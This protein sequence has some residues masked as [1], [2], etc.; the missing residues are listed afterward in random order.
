M[1]GQIEKIFI[2][3][4]IRTSYSFDSTI[5]IK[6][7]VG[8]CT[9]M[10]LPAVGRA[11]CNLFN[12]LEFADLLS[13][14]RIQPIIGCDITLQWLV[15]SSGISNFSSGKL[16]L[17]ASNQAGYKNLLKLATKTYERNKEHPFATLEDLAIYSSGIIALTGTLQ[18]GI[19]S[20]AR[21]SEQEKWLLSSI[22]DIYGD[23]SV[24]I[25]IQRHGY[26]DEPEFEFFSC[27]LANELKLP[28][29]ATNSVF[30]LGKEQY[31][32]HDAL[33]CI[34]NKTYVGMRDRIKFLP[35][36]YLRSAE[37]MIKIFSDKPEAIVNT[38]SIA[39]RCS[40]WPSKSDVNLPYADGSCSR[41]M[42]QLARNGLIEKRPII[43]SHSPFEYEEYEKRLE[44]ELDL[45]NK[46]NFSGYFTIVSDF[47]QWAKNNDIPVGPGRGSAAGSLVSW[48]LGIIG[49]DPL[50]FGLLFERFLNPD[51]ISMPDID[52]DICQDGR[53]RVIDYV[54]KKYGEKCVANIIT[55]GT[56]Q[57]RAALRDVGRVLQLPYG[58]IDKICR[59][60]PS[61]AVNPLTLSQVLEHDENIRKLYSEDETVK[62][63]IDIC[64][65]L[66][67][68]YRHSSLH[69]AGV[70]IS[71]YE[72]DDSMPIC[73]DPKTGDV[74]TQ[75]S[76]KFVEAAG[77]IKFDFLGLRTLTVINNA[78]KL[79]AKKFGD[80]AK[81]DSV[82]F[83]DRDVFDLLS[84]GFSVGV[85]HLEGVLM[86]NTMKKLKPDCL[87]D[88][89]ALL[90]LNRPGPIDNIGLYIDR[91]QGRVKIDY[92]HD[93]LKSV[94]EETFGIPVYQEQVMMMA[95]VVAGY[96]LGAAD[97]LR[98]AMGKKERLEMERQRDNFIEGALQNGYTKDMAHSLFD[99]IEKF[100]GYGFNKSHA[101]A[102]AIISYQTAWLKAKFTV[103]Y[104]V[105]FMNSEM[106]HS[107]ALIPAIYESQKMG[108]QILPPDVNSS[109][110]EFSISDDKILY[111]LGACKNVGVDAANAIV[112][113]RIYGGRFKSLL[114]FVTRLGSKSKIV[115]KRT[116]LALAKAGAFES[117]YD[118]QKNLINNIE[119]IVQ[120]MRSASS[121]L[122]CSADQISIWEDNLI[123]DDF[124]PVPPDDYC[125]FDKSEKLKEEFEA[126]GLLLTG[127][128]LSGMKK[129]LA[130]MGVRN[131]D[132]IINISDGNKIRLAGMVANSQ[133]KPGRVD[134]FVRLTVL[135]SSGPFQCSLYDREAIV[136]YSDFLKIGSI[137]VLE[138]R[139]TVRDGS[140]SLFVDKV[141]NAGGLN[142]GSRQIQEKKSRPNVVIY[143]VDGVDVVKLKNIL[144]IQNVDS[145]LDSTQSDAALDSAQLPKKI[146]IAVTDPFGNV[147]KIPLPDEEYMASN[148]IIG[149]LKRMIGVTKVEEY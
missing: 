32:S 31:K 72:I 135:D 138:I 105:A 52:V 145:T 137:L 34:Q 128:P 53:D 89:I 119:I 13:R 116:L 56:L 30:F 55:F 141:L 7:L 16:L 14:S 122:L 115:N 126:L 20:K 131:S 139:I 117:I 91:K 74:V 6:P 44:F 82:S 147:K 67:G 146:W 96:S 107:D 97:I 65:Q 140:R 101:A 88:L 99:L 29:V 93:N 104:L 114:D 118:K 149:A 106:H 1:R 64:V 27:A 22:V 111:S 98:R 120:S 49:L 63:M 11:D 133:T 17:I 94:L 100:A 60:V 70:V 28:I 18:D 124:M 79:A 109:M 103:Q 50:R 113:E 42:T 86:Q 81:V 85:F 19:L 35:T 10:N 48:C 142:I 37:E 71:D 75:Y 5:K 39:Q 4:R 26:A 108:I 83:L 69:A 84:K 59:M 46:M 38:I 25:E 47:I 41:M 125:E 112:Q 51:R 45:I 68:L 76:M 62:E 92:Y 127:D 77:M 87:E 8:A 15:K 12:I 134:K 144:K 2:H 40:Y 9:F 90:S 102:Y 95:R 129:Q 78:Q 21:R 33:I 136:K 23:R 73:R 24:F 123:N 57:T 66:E 43:E 36:H 110:S 61:S 121:K 130:E 143:V 58:Y 132:H 148:E 80:D 54:R 3:L